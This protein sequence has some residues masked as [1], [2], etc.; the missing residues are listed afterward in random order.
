MKKKSFKRRILTEMMVPGKKKKPTEKAGDLVLK[1]IT[2]MLELHIDNDDLDD[3]INIS[4]QINKI[5][6]ELNKF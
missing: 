6:D 4:H 1:M 2:L 5:R 3:V